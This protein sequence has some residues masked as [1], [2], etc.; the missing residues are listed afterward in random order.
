[1]MSVLSFIE[2]YFYVYL[3]LITTTFVNIIVPLAGSTIVNP[4]TAYLTD[5]QRAIGIGAF[6]FCFTG[7]HRVYLFRREIV[8]DDNNIRTITTILPYSIIGA[9]F[10]GSFISYLNIKVLVIIIVAVSLY[11]ICK[12]LLQIYRKKDIQK[13]D[14]HLSKVAVSIIS[15]FLQGSG[16][17]GSDIRNNY[18]RTTLSE[19]SVRAVGSVIGIV[20]F[21]I[22]GVIIFLHNRLTTKD[23]VFIITIVPLL[24]PVQMFG[25]KFLDK[26]ADKHAKII[27]IIFSLLGIILLSYKYLL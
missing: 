9:I 26:L 5:P 14:N 13:S 23:I 18:L 17:P 25:K 6:I 2:D 3:W 10:G 4:V 12:T 20:N 24:L 16:M 22:A 7:L 15:G 27:A 1:M 21:F 8:S 19:V 11:F